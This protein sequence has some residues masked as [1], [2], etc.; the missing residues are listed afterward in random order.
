MKKKYLVFIILVFILFI[1]FLGS[2]IKTKKF[3][4][5][6][7]TSNTKR[8]YSKEI[9]KIEIIELGKKKVVTSYNINNLLDFL[10]SLK[11][12]ELPQNY[13]LDGNVY[14][15][16]IINTDKSKISS[17]ILIFFSNKM[18]WISY[19][20]NNKIIYNKWYSTEQNYIDNIRKIYLYLK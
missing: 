1:L 8:F 16:K 7:M 9:N 4:C 3:S 6:G 5:G 19:D 13:N 12:K 15:I 10:N 14:S 2:I 17:Q 18:H 20:K 11:I